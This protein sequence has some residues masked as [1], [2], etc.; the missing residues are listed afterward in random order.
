M[1]YSLFQ[2]NYGVHVDAYVD[3]PFFLCFYLSD[4]HWKSM[5]SSYIMMDPVQDR[6]ERRNKWQTLVTVFVIYFAI[7]LSFALL[8]LLMFVANKYRLLCCNLYIHEH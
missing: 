5:F 7:S 2:Q 4:V 6:P 3:N 8:L 1:S